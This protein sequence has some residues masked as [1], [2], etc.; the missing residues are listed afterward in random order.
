MHKFKG[1]AR[2]KALGERGT[3]VCPRHKKIRVAG[4]SS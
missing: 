1:A 3:S 2:I 4:V